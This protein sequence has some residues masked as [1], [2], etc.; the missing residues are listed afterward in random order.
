MSMSVL[1][2]AEC[3]PLFILEANF[4]GL[5]GPFWGQMEAVLGEDLRAIH[6]PIPHQTQRQPKT[7][8][9]DCLRHIYRGQAR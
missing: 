5:P 2:A 8:R 1:P 3:A 7:V 9:L 6:Q 4:D